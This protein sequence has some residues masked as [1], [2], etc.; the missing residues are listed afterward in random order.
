[1]VVFWGTWCGPCMAD[2]PHHQA[3]LKRLEG[4]PFAIIGIDSEEKDREAVQKVCI[5][6]GITWRSFWDGDNTK[7]AIA[8][9]W[10]V[11]AWPTLYLLDS[12]GVIR[13]KGELLRSS[14]VR[15]TKEGKREPFRYLDDAVD[16][17]MK[18]ITPKEP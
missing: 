14:G 2:V 12:K 11:N 8:S 16:A 3:L 9:T 17:L 7:T 4:K 18:E 6:K 1:L 13:Y 10:N 15:E 5:D